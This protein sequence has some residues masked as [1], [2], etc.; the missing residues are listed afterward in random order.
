MVFASA[1]DVSRYLLALE[2]AGLLDYLPEL[3]LRILIK[4]LWNISAD[5][6]EALTLT[7]GDLFF[8]CSLPFVRRRTLKQRTP[9]RQ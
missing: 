7:L 9:R 2:I 5:I 1:L 3:C 6:N 4:T 8:N